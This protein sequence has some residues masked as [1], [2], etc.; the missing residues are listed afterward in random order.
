[1]WLPKNLLVC[2]PSENESIELMT[3]LEKVGVKWSDGKPPTA[4]NYWPKYKQNT[5]YRIYK[6]ILRYGNTT[7]Y[8]SEQGE[9]HVPEDPEYAFCSVQYVLELCGFEK[10][11]EIDY[12]L[13][14]NLL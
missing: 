3:C 4:Y 10:R 1:M 14:E 13:L 6:N 11:P 5:C 12:T 9:G 2:A 7:F 8:K